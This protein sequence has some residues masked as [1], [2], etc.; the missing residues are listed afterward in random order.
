MNSAF[1]TCEGSDS[2]F[3]NNKNGDWDGGGAERKSASTR[4]RFAVQLTVYDLIA[5][6]GATH[7]G[8][9][10]V[11]PAFDTTRLEGGG[12]HLR[13]ERPTIDGFVGACVM[14]VGY[15]GD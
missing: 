5:A 7:R 3:H 13:E 8:M 10:M 12:R 11:M 1:E 2:W 9:G 14:C 15:V 4:V 6:T